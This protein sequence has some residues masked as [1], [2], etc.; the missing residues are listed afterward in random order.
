L[1]FNNEQLIK[2]Y[3]IYNFEK[4]KANTGMRGLPALPIFA[5]FWLRELPEV[6]F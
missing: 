6:H 5:Y 2:Y 1:Y 3:E 4:N